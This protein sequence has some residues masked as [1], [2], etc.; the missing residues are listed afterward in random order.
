MCIH[1]HVYVC[2]NGSVIYAFINTYMYMYE[3][4]TCAYITQHLRP[5]HLD[6]TFH[7]WLETGFQRVTHIGSTTS[8]C[9]R[10]WIMCWLRCSCQRK[11]LWYRCFWWTF[12][13][14]LLIFTL[15]LQSFQ[16]CT[17][18]STSFIS[19]RSKSIV[20]ALL[21]VN[22]LMYK[23]FVFAIYIHIGLVPWLDIG[24]WGTRQSII[25]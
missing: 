21:Y 10:L 7:S 20:T 22:T 6:D 14:N 15:K 5:G 17:I 11:W 25:T 16:R 8:Q 23:H 4:A 9:C 12:S 2:M 24:Q 1:V 3:Y 13:L 19:L 18:C